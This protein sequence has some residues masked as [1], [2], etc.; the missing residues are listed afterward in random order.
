MG[1]KRTV[2]QTGDVQRGGTQVGVCLQRSITK[3]IICYRF[4][5]GL[6]ELGRNLVW[7][8]M[9]QDPS[10]FLNA[11]HKSKKS[12]QPLVV[13]ARYDICGHNIFAE[14]KLTTFLF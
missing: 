12:M 5:Y 1:E 13:V 11:Y 3:F 7:K 8:K 2:W 6:P 14:I 9:D 10:L 4:F